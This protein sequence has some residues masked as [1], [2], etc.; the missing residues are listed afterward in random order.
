[1]LGSSLY[2]QEVDL[3]SAGCIFGEM[4]VGKPVFPGSSTM[5]QLDMILEVTGMPRLEDVD[6]LQ[7]PFA[8][9]MLEAFPLSNT[10]PRPLSTIFAG[11]HANRL[12]LLQSLLRFNPVLRMSAVQALEHRSL[13][14]FHDPDLEIERGE[15]I[16]LPVRDGTRYPVAAYRDRLYED[17]LERHK[18]PRGEDILAARAADIARFQRQIGS[19]LIPPLQLE[20]TQSVESCPTTRRASG[21][22]QAAAELEADIRREIGPCSTMLCSCEVVQACMSASRF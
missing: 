12:D 19:T 6:A 3:W 10:R 7:S 21:R 8:A 4:M 11:V 17:I 14:D 5:N 2:S 22:R 15:P 9:T 16:I 18:D 1:M 20:S 13:S